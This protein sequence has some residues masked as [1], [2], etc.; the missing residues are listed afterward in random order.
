MKNVILYCR[1][2]SDEQKTNTSLDFQERKLREHCNAKG[3]NVIACYHEDFSAKHHDFQRPEMRKIRDYCKKHKHEVDLI[4]FLR[5]DRFSRNPE[6]AYM[7]KR[8]FYDDWGIEFNALESPIDFEATEW[9]N[10]LSQYCST[11]HTENN[12]ISRR[13]RDG[14]RETLLSG[15]WTGVAPRGYKN[16]HIVDKH[17]ITLSKSVEVDEETAPIIQQIFQ[18]VGKGIESPALIRRRIAPNIPV[19]SFFELLRN[20]FYKGKIRVPATKNDPEIIVD[21]VHEPLVTEELFNRV[22]E[23]I[24]GK[25]KKQPKLTK[26]VNPEFYLRKFLVCPICGRSITGAISTGCRGGKYPYYFCPTTGKHLRMSADEVNNKFIEYIYQLRPNNAILQI[27]SEIL[28]TLRKDEEKAIDIELQKLRKEEQEIEERMNKIEDMYID[29]ELSKDDFDRM[30]NRQ[31]KQIK[32]IQNKAQLLRTPNR[33]KIEPQLRYAINLMDNIDRFFQVAAAEDKIRV[34]SS[35][36]LGK[37][38]FDGENFRT[39]NFN[40]VLGLIYQQSNELGENEK[41]ESPKIIENSALV[42]PS[43]IEL[44]SKV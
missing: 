9:S 38:E 32:M 29:R 1:V 33:T 37:I 18:E 27:Y 30:I 11:A 35:I 21:G 14:I 28:D 22:Q 7:F 39:K 19:S 24:D 25:R 8:I 26:A 13:T 10:P 36:F 31:R 5:W 6:F 12:K 16:V 44:L 15:R 20:I 42:P 17:G 41:A 43:R 3:Y 34:L 23:V 4:L 2:S 40:S